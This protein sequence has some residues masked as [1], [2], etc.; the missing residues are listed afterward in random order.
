MSARLPLTVGDRLVAVAALI[1]D[2]DALA[3]RSDI[4]TESRDRIEKEAESLREEFE[5]LKEKNRRG[6]IFEP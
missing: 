2:L 4:S 3:L 6:V 1:A 5:D